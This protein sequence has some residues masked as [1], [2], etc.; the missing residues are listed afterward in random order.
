MPKKA[1]TGGNRPT[2]ANLR[3]AMQALLDRENVTEGGE[4]QSG[5]DQIAAALFA[6]ATDSTHPN[7]LKAIETIMKLTDEPPKVQYENAQ[8]L[9]ALARM[10]KPYKG[11]ASLAD[12]D[13]G[14]TDLVAALKAELHQSLIEQHNI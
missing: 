10:T 1:T 13:T 4:L 7:C 6:A 11:M 8:N 2:R 14:D 5:A 12:L 9:L 3:A